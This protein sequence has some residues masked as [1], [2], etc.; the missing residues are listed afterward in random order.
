MPNNVI[1]N[2][3][4]SSNNKLCNCV[5]EDSNIKPNSTIPPFSWVVKGRKKGNV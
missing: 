4:I 1:K 2:S 3:K 5:I